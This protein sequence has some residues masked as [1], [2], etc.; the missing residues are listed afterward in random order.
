[1]SVE[2][3]NVKTEQEAEIEKMKQEV[4]YASY[5]KVLDQRKADQEK[6][7]TLAAKLAELESEKKARDEAEMQKRGEYEKLLKQR[8]EELE[9]ERSIAKQNAE[10]VATTW[11][12]NAVNSALQKEGA[13]IKKHD[14]FSFVDFNKIGFDSESMRVDDDSLKEVVNG[15]ITNYPDLVEREN[16]GVPATKQAAQFDTN[17]LPKTPEEKKKALEDAL[18]TIITRN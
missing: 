3:E 9:R 15:F 4:D 8:E 5:K 2:N 17:S 6:A 10:K 16:K 1:M 18:K 11:K 7:K 13:R 14:Y 12:L